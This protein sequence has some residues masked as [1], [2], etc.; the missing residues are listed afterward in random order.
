MQTRVVLVEPEYSSNVGAVCRVMKNFGLSE[1]FVVNPKCEIRGTDA[2]KGAKHAKNVLESA[3]TVKKFGDAVRNCDS[4]IGTTGIKLRHKGTIRSAVGLREFAKKTDYYKDKKI[5]LV[6]GREGTG[7]NEDELNGCDLLLHVE[8]SPDYPVLNISHAAAIIFYS[9]SR[10][11]GGQAEKAP[12]KGELEALKRYFS[13]I[14]K[15]FERRNMR[16]PVAFR[17]IISRARINEQ[18]AKALINL[19]RLVSERLSKK[20]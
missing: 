17:R 1:L 15:R 9:I 2:Y 10:I 8:A 12:A 3:K 11:E 4:V 5:A 19:F 16:A 6:F 7:L 14:S 18:E 13:G 20:N